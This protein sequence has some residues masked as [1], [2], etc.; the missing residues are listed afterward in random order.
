MVPNMRILGQLCKVRLHYFN[1]ISFMFILRL[2]NI[3][4][5][6]FVVKFWGMSLK[7]DY[8][9]RLLHCKFLEYFRLRSHKNLMF[10]KYTVYHSVMPAEGTSVIWTEP[11]GRMAH[12]A[13]CTGTG[14][15]DWGFSCSS[16]CPYERFDSVLHY[17]AI[18]F[19]IQAFDTAWSEL[20]TASPNHKLQ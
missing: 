6:E 12:H 19:H 5:K 4:K 1:I 8:G 10:W 9:T 11:W 2:V 7:L 16:V 17:T 15:T 13:L 3:N 20:V 14:Y 18:S